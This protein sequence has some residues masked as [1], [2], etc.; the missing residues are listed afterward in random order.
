VDRRRLAD[1]RAG[2]ADQQ[3]SGG[4]GYLVGHRL[5]LTCRHVVFDDQGRPWP[6]LEAW[7]G[8]PSDGPRQRVPAEVVWTHP[9]HDAALLR[10][11]GGPFNGASF[12]RWGWVIGS[13]PVAYA[14]LG[15]PEF[16]DYESGRGVEQLGGVLPP[17]T[18]GPD[19]GLVLDQG[20]APETAGERAWPGVSGAAVFCQ[21]LLTAVVIKDDRRFGNRRLHAVP[22]SGLTKDP[23]F[24]RLVAED[25]GM[26][27]VLE[28]VELT[29]YSQPPPSPVL[30]R[31]P[32]S[33]L[34][35]AVKAMEFTGRDKELADLAA[36]RDSGEAFSVMLVTGEGGQGKTR[37]ADKFSA[38]ARQTGW[39]AGFLAPRTSGP[40]H[41]DDRGQLPSAV[42]LTQRVRG[43]TRPVLLVADY[44]ETRPDEI[45]AL[46]DALGSS[47][48]TH[49]VRLLLLSRSTGAWWANLTE[50]L[51][52][53][54]HR[55]SLEPLTGA[56]QTRR[57]AYAAAVTGLARHVAALPDPPTEQAPDR[58]WTALA[59]ELAA[60]P[61][62]LDDPR[63]GNAL[64]LQI[65]ALSGLLAGSAVPVSPRDL[66]E[67]DLIRHERGYLRR[68]AAKRGLFNQGILSDR[69]DNDERIA[70]VWAALEQALAGTIVLGPCDARQARRLATLA[71]QARAHDVENWLA[72]L[73]PPPSE[74]FHVGS[75]QPDRLAELLLG[76]IL[77]WQPALLSQIGALTEAPGDAYTALFTVMRTVAHPEFSR[78]GEQ[79]A[80]LIIS[81]PDPF[82]VAAPVLA[83]T[84]AQSG[85]LQ[86]GLIRLGK[87]D[88]ESFRRHAFRVFNQLPLASV[89]GA[90]FITALTTEITSILHVLAEADPGTYLPDLAGALNNLGIRRSDA[91]QLQAALTPA[92]EA[93]DTYRQLAQAHPDAYVPALA[94][95]LN[96]LGIRRSDAGQLQAA[97]TPAEEAVDTY[98]QLAQAN[99][100]AYL[101]NL[102]G[103]LSNLDNHLADAGQRQAAL[104]AAKEAVTI[105][106]ELAAANPSTYL[107]NLAMALLNFGN[108]LAKAGQRQA[109]LD[110]AK[111]AADAYRQLAQAN[112]DAYLPELAGALT[113]LG[114]RLADTGQL[115]AALAPAK[116]AAD[117]Y[118]RLAETN[119]D[120]YLPNFA[121]A[122]NNLGSRLAG[123]GQR[124]AALDPAEEAVTIHRKLAAANRDAHLPDLAMALA[125]LGNHLGKVGE[126]Q[127]ALDAAN[128]AVGTYRQLARANS[129]AYLPDLA[130][131]LNNLGNHLAD[132]GE[133]QAA[134]EAAEEAVT[135]HRELAAANPSTHLPDLAMALNNLGIRLAESGD[136]EA[137][138]P[139]QEAAD[140]YR[141]LAQNNPGA[142][143]PGLAMAL[144]NLG[145]HLAIAGRRQTALAAAQEAADTYRQLARANPNT[146]LP[147][148]GSALN[149]LG[150]QLA[151][152][153]ERQA[154][155]DFAKEAVNIYYQLAKASPDAFLPGL[156]TALN[157]LKARLAE[158]GYDPDAP[159][160]GQS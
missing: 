40:V 134:L 7:L 83:A 138:T 35:A 81:H 146:Y 147:D 42:G 123:T 116:E 99:P 105:H 48:P 89:S 72:A 78:I 101:P 58:S 76:P 111:E 126:R 44:A 88:R 159:A 100:D 94:G 73:Y 39:A 103:A 32:G 27:A 65:T 97:L 38:Q 22:A 155:L 21:G 55:I 125:N 153:G 113:N 25:T 62:S 145:N 93:V 120:A 18:V 12:V 121:K 85:P 13:A 33:L 53:L 118:R 127:A 41:G 8:H 131:A 130:R 102:A 50:A 114:N 11:A 16:A 107:P 149:N 129:D 150:A 90:L 68:A 87:H 148:L 157:N 98:R 45:A 86:D 17:L 137:L 108:H 95:A 30:A 4:S 92:E 49:P 144:A 66:G 24:A 70:E 152:T 3:R 29:E 154:A 110:P 133:R 142:Y 128:E 106:R 26:G 61:P 14:G 80:G 79:A 69:S 75:V 132:A 84:L 119:P 2:T 20:A 136:R 37:L 52:H 34:A 56:G 1:V 96:N 67:R 59:E 15:Y 28:A 43:V 109:A 51:G 135:I 151:D 10:F 122:L 160:D 60:H 47:P 82:A 23:G 5:I 77:L 19:G 36:W 74:E 140:T 6:R 117:T 139:A 64:T 143:R 115:R 9:D 91:G 57:D 141:Q 31:T 71:S 104:E 112:P 124:Q 158:A 63:L 156:A 54:T 46:A